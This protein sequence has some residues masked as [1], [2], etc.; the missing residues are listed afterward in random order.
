MPDWLERQRSKPE[1]RVPISS[2]SICRGDASLIISAWGYDPNFRC[3]WEVFENWVKESTQVTNHRHRGQKRTGFAQQ[4]SKPDCAIS[5]RN[6]DES[7]LSIV[8]ILLASLRCRCRRYTN[9]PE[10]SSG[11]WISL[12]PQQTGVRTAN[13]YNKSL[14]CPAQVYNNWEHEMNCL[15]SK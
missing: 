4:L 7:A 12:L 3:R 11:T 15:H 10:Q 14:H 1:T 5:H 9:V 13:Y 6:C 2:L 8:E